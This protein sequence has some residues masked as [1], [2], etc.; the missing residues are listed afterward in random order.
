M[1]HRIG[2]IYCHNTQSKNIFV[3]HGLLASLLAVLPDIRVSFSI[4]NEGFSL[5]SMHLLMLL[6][7][8]KLIGTSCDNKNKLADNKLEEVITNSLR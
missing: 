1:T 7:F 4:I 2:Y 8:Q 6:F 3:A 5:I